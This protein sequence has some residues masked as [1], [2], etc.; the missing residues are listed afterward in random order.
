MR[1][2]LL[3]MFA[4]LAML[5]TG[6]A[7]AQSFYWYV[8]T[9]EPTELNG[10]VANAETDKW[11][12]IATEIPSYINVT[13][14]SDYNFPNWYVLMPTAFG[15]KPHDTAGID[16]ES[17]LWETSESPIGGYTL[18]SVKDGMSEIQTIFK[19][20]GNLPYNANAD[21]WYMGQIDP[22][23]ATE[24]SPIVVYNWASPYDSWEDCKLL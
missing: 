21:Y 9:T 11:V 1:T 19:K 15:F 8:G 20:I 17:P 18:Y 2:K 7:N 5:V 4:T 13:T 14:A 3:T 24:I 6:S 23:S 12:E 22:S 16:D 10:A